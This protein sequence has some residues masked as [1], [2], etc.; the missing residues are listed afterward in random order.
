LLLSSMRTLFDDCSF[1]LNTKANIVM[2]T[3]D[4]L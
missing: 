1:S 3:N 2:N 4:F